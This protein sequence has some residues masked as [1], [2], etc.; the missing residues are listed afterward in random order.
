MLTVL[1]SSA[2]G[3]GS[4]LGI[5]ELTLQPGK[6]RSICKVVWSITSPGDTRRAIS[7]AV[8]CLKGK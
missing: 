8:F 4:L 2:L 7:N 3:W 1:E 5:G 6:P